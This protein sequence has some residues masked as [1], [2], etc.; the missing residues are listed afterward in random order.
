MFTTVNGLYELSVKFLIPPQHGV[1]KKQYI[2]KFVIFSEQLVKS[3]GTRNH[4]V[5]TEV[6]KFL[7]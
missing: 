5:F 6:S 4:G 7:L 2:Y 3:Y 1:K